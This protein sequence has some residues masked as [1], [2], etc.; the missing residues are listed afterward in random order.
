MKRKK[1]NIWRPALLNEEQKFIVN[2]YITQCYN[3]HRP[4]NIF[5]LIDVIYNNFNVFISYNT[6]YKQIQESPH[7]K[8]VLAP[9]YETTRAEVK[10]ADIK[11]Y[12]EDL[13]NIFVHTN[14]PPSF[15]INVDESGFV[16]Y[17]DERSEIVVVPIGVPDGTVKSVNRSSKR[18]TMIG[19][20]S[21][22]GTRLKPCIIL[23]GKRYDKKL[24]VDGYGKQNVDVIHQENGFVNSSSFA[25]WADNILFPLIQ[26]RRKLT[27]YQGEVVLLLD[28]CTSHCSDYFLD[29]CT[30]YNVIPFFEPPGSS[31]QVQA[32]DLGILRIQ[33]CLKCRIK[34]K[35]DLSPAAKEVIQIVNSWIKTTTP[36]NVTSAFNQAGIYVVEL[37]DG[38]LGARASVEKARAVR[39]I[40]HIECQ[41]EINGNK[42]IKLLDFDN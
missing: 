23:T 29:Q 32:L 39:N 19:A 40:D 24:I 5:A 26:E 17:I 27:G 28:G 3:E 38:S 16:E 9:V 35:K 18:S 15:I 33:K 14:V 37:P 42:T 10:L 20:I 34:T 2:E 22:D 31:D 25:Y 7:I 1:K 13:N 11:Q 12:Y 6:I 30:F 21:L 4:L 41:N 36:D 8:T